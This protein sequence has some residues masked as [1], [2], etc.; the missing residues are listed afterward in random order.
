MV[1]TFAGANGA[2]YFNGPTGV[3]VGSGGNVYV[4]DYGN[5]RVAQI[6]TSGQVITIA[7]LY[8][9][10]GLTLAADG[11]IYVSLPKYNQVWQINSEEQAVPFAGTGTVG[12]ENGIS[13]AASFYS[14]TGI[15]ADAKGNIYVA[16][17]GNNLIRKIV[18]K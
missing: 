5:D 4:A 7:H 12:S 18:I 15:A 14:P 6:N 10:S 3:I 1:T 16:D 8:Y 9:P 17:S 13:A 2:G 11:N